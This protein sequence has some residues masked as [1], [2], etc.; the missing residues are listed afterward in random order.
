MKE[1]QTLKT[2]SN[3]NDVTSL[4]KTFDTLELNINNVKELKIVVS[5][6]G[7]L[8]ITII[9]DCIPEELHIK[10]SLNFGDE[11]WKLNE[12]MGIIKSGLE[13]RERSL[14]ISGN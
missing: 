8:L 3:I 14:A 13:A 5:T 10:I 12:T 7:S 9:F 4:R 11:E 2:V 6:Y 1:L